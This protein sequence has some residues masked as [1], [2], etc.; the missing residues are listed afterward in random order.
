LP[1]IYIAAQN[2]LAECSRMDECQDWADKAAALA[3]YARQAE[4]E[5]LRKHA[6]RI[7]SRAIRRCSE[8]LNQYPDGH[9]GNR[10]TDQVES[11]HNLSKREAALGAGLSD[12]QYRTARAIGEIPQDQFESAVD[13]DNPPTVTELARMGTQPRKPVTD[14][15]DR[16]PQDFSVSTKAQGILRETAKAAERLDPETIV[17]G[18]LPNE[19]A[20]IRKHIEAIDAW[21]DKIIV[22]LEN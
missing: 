11:T 7:Q 17:K 22:R 18:A 20:T 10:K 14:L 3:S 15:Q 13:S 16:N 6:E 19:H 1:E 8:L 5:T 9:G 12:W 4:D 2:A 21:L